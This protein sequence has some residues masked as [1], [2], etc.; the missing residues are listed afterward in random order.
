VSAIAAAALVDDLYR[1]AVITPGAIDEATLTEWMEQAMEAVT[2]HR[3]M[4]RPLRAAVRH[5]R[6]L[7]SRL[8]GSGQRFPDWRNGVDQ[9]LGTRGWE[10]Q[11]DL[12]RLGLEQSPD[13]EVFAAVKE[14]HRAVHF[15]EWMEGVEYE[16]WLKLTK[17]S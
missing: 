1:Q 14:R 6:R 10:P 2:Y 7:A 11:L 9:V 8:D 3:A 4:A 15:T 17:G 16:E 12:V 5:A 13:P